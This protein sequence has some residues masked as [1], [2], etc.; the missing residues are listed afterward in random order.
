MKQVRILTLRRGMHL[1]SY[2]DGEKTHRDGSPFFDARV[3][4]NIRKAERFYRDLLRAGYRP[5]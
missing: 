4:G 2:H 5:T 3:F 1:V